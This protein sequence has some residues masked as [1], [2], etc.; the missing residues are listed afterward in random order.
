[1]APPM[2]TIPQTLIFPF[3]KVRGT[4]IEV[5]I[6]RYAL[7][8]SK[9]LV[10]CKQDFFGRRCATTNKTTIKCEQLVL[11]GRHIIHKIESTDAEQYRIPSYAEGTVPLRD[12]FWV[13]EGDKKLKTL[14]EPG[15]VGIYTPAMLTGKV[16]VLVP[17]K[18]VPNRSKRDTHSVENR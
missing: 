2:V 1:M 3:C 8:D 14:L 18:N 16:T 6:R 13:C 12:I 4:E 10:S 15:W 9:G 17:Q 11:D 7:T 5:V